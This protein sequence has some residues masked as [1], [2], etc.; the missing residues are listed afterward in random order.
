MNPILRYA[1]VL[2]VFFAGPLRSEERRWGFLGSDESLVATFDDAKHVG[3][4]CVTEVELRDVKPPFAKVVYHATVIE[5]HKGKL[6][7]GA[8]IQ[9]SFST[10]SLPIDDGERLKFVEEANKKNK[11][12]LK[13]AFLRGGEEGA[14]GCDFT[15]VPTYSKE[16]QDFLRKLQIRPV[17]REAEAAAP[18]DGGKSSD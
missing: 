11:G 2:L 9:I 15:E 6:E 3:F 10:D 5:C 17:K 8:K 18:G 16:M 7:V 1:A 13:F 14:Y 4:V 12:E